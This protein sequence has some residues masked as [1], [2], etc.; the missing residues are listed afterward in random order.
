MFDFEPVF[1][2]LKH[3]K[4]QQKSGII[5]HNNNLSLEQ[6]S[7]QMFDLIMR[8]WE[9][10]SARNPHAYFFDQKRKHRKSSMRECDLV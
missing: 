5:D 6:R 8:A 7:C 4:A 2:L 9:F 10:W 3:P 1:P